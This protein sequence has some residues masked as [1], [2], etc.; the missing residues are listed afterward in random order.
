MKMKLAT[1]IIFLFSSLSALATQEYVPEN[2]SGVIEGVYCGNLYEYKGNEA[3]KLVERCILWINSNSQ[4]YG[5]VASTNGYLTQFVPSGEKNDIVIGR[6]VHYQKC[7]RPLKQEV[8]TA[9]KAGNLPNNQYVKCYEYSAKMD[10]PAEKALQTHIIEGK[11]SNKRGDEAEIITH[12]SEEA[13]LFKPAVFEIEIIYYK[14]MGKGEMQEI[15]IQPLESDSLAWINNP[16][17][18]YFLDSYTDDC[19]DPDCFNTDGLVKFLTNKDG[20]Y[21]LYLEFDHYNNAPTGEEG[22]GEDIEG[23]K[24]YLKKMGELD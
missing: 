14:N 9:I 3:N 20:S 15:Y 12:L 5:I 24:V 11:Y 1:F 2:I 4:V 6:T 10:V 22:V 8:A 16:K 17:R 21:T 19:Q 18:P 13:T 23:E 7:G